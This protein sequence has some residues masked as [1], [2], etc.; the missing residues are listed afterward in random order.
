M[1]IK[2]IYYLNFLFQ[3]HN[4]SFLW[5]VMKL[6]VIWFQ[7]AFK[8]VTSPSQKFTRHGLTAERF[9]CKRSVIIGTM[10]NFDGDGHGHWDGT[11]KRA[12]VIINFVYMINEIDMHIMTKCHEI[13]EL[14]CQY[15]KLNCNDHMHTHKRTYG[16][17]SV[18]TPLRVGTTKKTVRHTINAQP[19]S[20]IVVFFVRKAPLVC[21]TGTGHAAPGAVSDVQ[22]EVA[23]FALH[24]LEVMGRFL[25]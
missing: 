18:A 13:C 20:R 11:C 10:L 24:A 3:N 25:L 17:R 9:I 19:V 2:R 4:V 22:I 12:L 23:V 6:V 16:H 7:L 21:P 14:W 8:I 15:L 5:N 1:L